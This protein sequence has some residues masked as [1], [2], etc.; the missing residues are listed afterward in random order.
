LSGRVRHRGEFWLSQAA[1]SK[2]A[3]SHA[4]D[5][6]EGGG[7]S[8]AAPPE[9]LCLLLELRAEMAEMREQIGARLERL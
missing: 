1:T 6:T 2:R 4:D 7:R 3:R 5:T 9:L 8:A